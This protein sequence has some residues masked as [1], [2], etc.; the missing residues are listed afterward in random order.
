MSQAASIKERKKAVNTLICAGLWGLTAVFFAA[1]HVS[2][3]MTPVF[4]PLLSLLI[5][6]QFKAL[7]SILHP[8]NGVKH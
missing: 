8:Y 3:L 6:G 2:D 1:P 7:V 4:V 5:L